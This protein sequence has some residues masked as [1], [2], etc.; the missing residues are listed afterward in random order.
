MKLFRIINNILQLIIIRLY[1]YIKDN[2]LYIKEQSKL[3][4]VG[5]FISTFSFIK[6]GE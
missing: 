6:N 2:L 4:R 3:K 5:T 1:R